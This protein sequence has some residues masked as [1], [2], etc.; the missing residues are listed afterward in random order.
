M[1]NIVNQK[2]S[3]GQGNELLNKLEAAGLS[4]ALA[5]KV[6]DSK[7]NDLAMKVVRLIQN[8]GFEPT[9][10]QKRSRE[11]M[12]KNYF[13]IEEAIKHFGVNPSRQ[14]LA[15]LAE[16]PF[17][18]AVLEE[19][20]NTHILVAVFPLSILDIRGKVEREFYYYRNEEDIPYN[21]QAFVKEQGKV[22]WQ[23]V[24]KTEVTNSTCKNWS[25]RQALLG[26][27][28]EVPSARVMVYSIIGHRLNTGK[29]LFSSMCV[30][31]TDVVSDGRRVAVGLFDFNGLI[32]NYYED[33]ERLAYLGL[34]SS[35]KF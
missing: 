16:V 35:R 12:D 7:G 24:R 25:E 26:R 11:I 17:S 14:Q 4:G 34:A 5:Q 33:G 21:N 31:T 27:D 32:I 18:E 30:R 3:R 10:S 20:K 8:N 23:L 28:E 13:G 2:M 15:A 1:E 19:C 22:N 29:C 9:T 6:I